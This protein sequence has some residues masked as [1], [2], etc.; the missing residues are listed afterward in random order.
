MEVAQTKEKRYGG[1]I[2]APYPTTKSL[3]LQLKKTFELPKINIQNLLQQIT[4]PVC[5]PYT[6]IFGAHHVFWKDKVSTLHTLLPIHSFLLRAKFLAQPA[7]TRRAVSIAAPSYATASTSREQVYTSRMAGHE[8][9][10]TLTLIRSAPSLNRRSSTLKLHVRAW[11]PTPRFS[12]PT[13]GIELYAWKV[14]VEV[15]TSFF[16]FLCNLCEQC[17]CMV[18][19]F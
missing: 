8:H 6:I 10:A 11:L 13:I 2:T 17:H 1:I 12:H 14:L 9:R 18:Y 7:F 4:Y 16:L 3:K 15:L 5:Y 19:N